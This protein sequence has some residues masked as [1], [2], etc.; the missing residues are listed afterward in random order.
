[1]LI[2]KPIL[3]KNVMCKLQK[4]IYSCM[5]ICVILTHININYFID[6][7]LNMQFFITYCIIILFLFQLY[8]YIIK[9]N[10]ESVH[11]NLIDLIVL[12]FYGY[13][14]L[15]NLF[16]S[17]N[18]YSEEF[19]NFSAVFCVYFIVCQQK[20][21]YH[22]NF[23][24]LKIMAFIIIFIEM[25]YCFL[26]WKNIIPNLNANYQIGGSY[27]HPG[28]TAISI[29]ILAP[30]LID[31]LKKDIF[32]NIFI[33]VF[34]PFILMLLLLFI[35]DSRAA[36][37]SVILSFAVIVIFPKIQSIKKLRFGIF[38]VFISLA[39][40]IIAF[41]KSDSSLGRAFVWKKCFTLIQEYPFFGVG[42]GRFAFEYNNYQSLFFS[43]SL[44]SNK[45]AFLADYS[46]S[47]FN[48]FFQ[49]GVEL[50]IIGIIFLI[51]LLLCFFKNKTSDNKPFF[52]AIICSFLPLFFGWSVLRYFPIGCFFFIGLALLSK[53]TSY[54]LIF[55]FRIKNQIIVNFSSFLLLIL[56]ALFT[57]NRMSYFNVNRSIQNDKNSQYTSNLNN[58]FR[59]LQYSDSYVYK[60]CDFLIKNDDYERA[61]FVAESSNKWLNSPALYHYLYKIHF[62]QKA[63]DKAVKDLDY[64]INI[65]PSK[66]YPKYALAKLYYSSGNKIKA[67]SLSTEILQIKPKVINAD[68]ILMKEELKAYLK[69]E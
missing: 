46:E 62:E 30:Y 38:T 27:G 69:K 21:L 29:A 47:A 10:L 17:T 43:K 14:F 66:I 65:S 34:L 20:K 5:L 22:I 37:L 58:A 1:M 63:Y 4:S 24:H 9:I 51:A 26:Q 12:A 35:L 57:Y 45:E 56:I 53:Q 36:V 41:T 25:T 31:N 49:F 16:L 8:L 13:L 6:D 68:V 2:I 52:N 32:R 55:S 61:A 60:Y 64:L 48:E 50:G 33:K 39:V 44:Q 59:E 19:I 40:S 11:L 23:N 28:F 42:F 18:I 7:F 54:E 15:N 3:F 67:D